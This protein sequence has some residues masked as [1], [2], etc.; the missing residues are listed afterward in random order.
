MATIDFMQKVIA[1]T[2]AECDQQHIP[3][4]VASIPNIPD[5]SDH[6]LR[7]GPSP[8]PALLLR[9]KLLEKAGVDSIVIP[10]NT[11]HYWYDPLQAATTV[12]IVNLIDSVADMALE[13]GFSNIGLLSTDATIATCLYQNALEKRG[14]RCMVPL[15]ELQKEMIV[16]INLY[17][18]GRPIEARAHL[19]VPYCYLLQQ[20]SEAIILGCTETPLILSDEI[21]KNRHFFLDSNE[22]LAR[23]VVRRYGK[24]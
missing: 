5:R 15:P 11:A 9:L 16:G 3:M 20:E 22:I 14:I 6:L 17:K 23:T 12:E 10:C 24:K 21:A 4:L 13:K 18:S 8:L 7:G 19:E 1:L 2:Q